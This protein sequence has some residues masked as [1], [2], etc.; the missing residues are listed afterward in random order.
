MERLTQ[1]SDTSVSARAG[2][3]INV[4]VGRPRRA[5]ITVAT[6]AGLLLAPISL[7]A[8][9]DLLVDRFT[10]PAPDRSIAGIITIGGGLERIDEAVRLAT[11]M[12]NLPLVV[13]GI[14]PAE[15][16]YIR[17][18]IADDRRLMHEPN[19]RTTAE[20][21]INTARLLGVESR[22]PWLL[23]TSNLHMPR[24]V[25]SF[26]RAGVNVVPWPVPRL[27]T[28][29]IDLVRMIAHEWAGLIVYR[30]LGRTDALLPGSHR[31]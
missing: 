19:A 18:A 12:P 14:H 22:R 7:L 4:R 29:R 30:V 28:G 3:T 31:Q 11:A 24:A 13:S 15:F 2:D 5:L 9:E 6:V 17:R 23:V 10:R 26:R 8:S 25:G 20:N 27:S 21:A 1:V 16:E